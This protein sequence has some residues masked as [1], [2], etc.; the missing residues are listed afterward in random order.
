MISINVI[1]C[2]HSK[3]SFLCI[4]H[5]AFY[6]PVLTL[7]CNK[8]PCSFRIARPARVRKGSQVTDYSVDNTY[9]LGANQVTEYSVDNTF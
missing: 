2:N 9:A 5:K 7:L 8:G 1:L 6:Y 3:W 4:L